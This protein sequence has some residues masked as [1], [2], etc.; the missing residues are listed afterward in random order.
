M[1]NKPW[2]ENIY[3]YEEARKKGIQE[4]IYKEDRKAGS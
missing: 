3:F 2:Y 4:E 1:F